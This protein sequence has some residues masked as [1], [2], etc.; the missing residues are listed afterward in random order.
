AI[1]AEEFCFNANLP[2][3][4]KAA[5]D[6][7]FNELGP[8]FQVF[9]DLMSSSNAFAVLT[10]PISFELNDARDAAEEQVLL[11]GAD[12]KELLDAIQTEFEPKLI[13]SLK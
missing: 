4:K 7:C 12:P 13:E 11:T 6:P 10:T 1:V 8:K 9:V 3:S 5:E 2:T